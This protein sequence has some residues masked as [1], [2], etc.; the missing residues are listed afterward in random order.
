M[1]G[2]EELLRPPLRTELGYGVAGS[3]LGTS[4]VNWKTARPRA[5]GWWQGSW[6]RMRI[7][8]SQLRGRMVRFV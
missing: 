2:H 4:K 6:P 3:T 5:C 1:K 8:G 7:N